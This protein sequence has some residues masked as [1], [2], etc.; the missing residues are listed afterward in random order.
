MI[1]TLKQL[2]LVL[3]IAW[4]VFRLAK[5]VALLFTSE[6]DFSRRRNTWYVV[7][8]AAFICPSFFVFALVVTP[9]LVVAGR[10]DSNPGALY[11]FLMFAVPPF[12]WRVPMVGISFLID[13]DFQ[14][15]LSFCVMAPVAVR[16]IK[17]RQQIPIR[18]FE[19]L[20][21]SVLAYLILTSIFFVLPEIGRG[22]IMT[23]TLTDCLRRAFES[24]F[25]IFVPY[26]VLSRSSTRREIQELLVA[27][28]VVCAVMAAIATFE[29]AKHWLLYGQIRGQWGPHYNPYLARGE[30]L[31]A[32][33]STAHPLTL[34]YI[35]AL[36]FGFWLCLKSNVKSKFSQITITAL[37]WLGLLAAYSRGPWL[38]AVIIYFI[39]TALSR[40]AVSGLFKAAGVSALIAV[41][42]AISPLGDKVLKVI[43]YFGG[44]VD[45][46]NIT[47]RQRLLERAWE[48]V[49]DSPF[50]GDQRAL[51]KMEDLRA[52]G[53]IDLMNGFMNILLDN[54]FVGLSL[55]LSFVLIGLYRAWSL[56]R[57]GVQ[58]GVELA[59]TG[60]SLVA[61]IL[62]LMLMMWAGGLIILE[63]CIL[64]GLA[65]ACARLGQTQRR[66]L[67]SAAR[68]DSLVHIER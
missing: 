60:A 38:G 2:F 44:T 17:S 42:V 52:D 23:P 10:K 3:V 57:Q 9:F 8:I 16:L 67:P 40:R 25:E 66:S 21:Y 14:M 19:V 62:G 18:R 35:L 4:A 15:L 53:I 32:M 49:Q 51:S 30:S 28:C 11:L 12:S 65:S 34:G 7:T 43:P 68:N 47:Y 45:A 22:V 64:V 26:Y 33:A 1:Q 6:S 63:M 36:A 41:I 24:C 31:R 46:Q 56:S 13:L 58:I 61:C 48:I 39:Y 59:A 37:Y 27:F 50:L 54:G 5:P 20:D 29:G 55:Y